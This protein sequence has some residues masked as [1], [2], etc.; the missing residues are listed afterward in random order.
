M[1][2]RTALLDELRAGGLQV[3]TR[4]ADGT[5]GAVFVIQPD[6]DVISQIS[7]PFL[8]DTGA[9]ARHLSSIAETLEA[10]RGVGRLAHVAVAAL[11]GVTGYLAAQQHHVFALTVVLGLFA[12]LVLGR[13]RQR[14]RRGAIARR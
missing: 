3:V 7:S 5:V 2:L 8:A 1:K 11:G 4:L 10:L 14:V 13:L 12:Q 6:G 9:Q